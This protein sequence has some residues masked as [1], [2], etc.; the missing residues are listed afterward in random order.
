MDEALRRYASLLEMEAEHLL[1][2]VDGAYRA[3]FDFDVF[4]PYSYVYFAAASYG[5][6]VQ[7]LL[8][9][10]RGGGEWAWQG[11]LG[12]TD[13]EIR[14]MVAGGGALV[15]APPADCEARMRELIAPRNVAGLA[16]AARHRMYPVDLDYLVGQSG[17]LGLDAEAIRAALP[18]LRGGG[19]RSEN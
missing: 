13:P 11:F 8:P 2:V 19:G 10:P 1:Q 3:R 5:A 4:A 12:A 18:R 9:S 14:R 7:R 6:V 16:D 17:L 15:D